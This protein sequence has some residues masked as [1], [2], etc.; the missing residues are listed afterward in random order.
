MGSIEETL[1]F[2]DLL[3]ACQERL[4]LL[5]FYAYP[6]KSWWWYFYFSFGREKKILQTRKCSCTTLALDAMT[7]QYILWCYHF[8]CSRQLYVVVCKSYFPCLWLFCTTE[9]KK[10][11]CRGSKIWW[12]NKLHLTHLVELQAIEI[13]QKS[14][15]MRPSVC[16]F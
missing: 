1:A 4:L 5:G 16:V 10:A 3:R 13:Y 12:I 6:S 14:I 2:A 7:G 11:Y 9:K 15:R 8:I